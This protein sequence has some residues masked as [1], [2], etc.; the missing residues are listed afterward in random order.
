MAMKKTLL[1]IFFI[2]LPLCANAGFVGSIK[3]EG[4]VWQ[5]KTDGNATGFAAGPVVAYNHERY[6]GSLGFTLGS[7]SGDADASFGRNELELNAGYRIMPAISGFVSFKQTYI[8]YNNDTVELSYDD[9]ISTLGVGA[10]LNYPLTRELMLLSTLAIYPSWDNY[11]SSEQSVSGNGFGSG[12]E[13]GLSYRV[14]RTTA[15][16]AR[17][18]VHAT[19]LNYDSTETSW[20]SR[21][22]RLGLEVVHAF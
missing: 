17:A 20:N 3:T 19:V 8:D 12:G 4:G 5:T 21:L 18:K 2:A 11:K 22:W 16:N 6:F 7:Y 1:L 9:T 13:I 14:A 15:I 10:A